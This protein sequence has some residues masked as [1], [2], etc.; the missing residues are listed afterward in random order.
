MVIGDF[1]FGDYDMKEQE[2]LE[3]YT[4]DVHDLWKDAFDLE[5]VHY[6]LITHAICF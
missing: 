1:N 4:N 5:K 3:K 2:M 6:D